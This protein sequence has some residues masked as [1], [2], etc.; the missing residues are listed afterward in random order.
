MAKIEI[1]ENQYN[2]T[3]D[4]YGCSNIAKYI[5]GKEGE[6]QAQKIIL[7]E[8]CLQGIINSVPLDMIFNRPEL[9]EVEE[10]SIDNEEKAEHDKKMT[11]ALYETTD[12]NNL[13]FN[14]LKD[15]ATQKGITVPF[16]TSKD[17]LIKLI[18]SK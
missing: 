13:K 3:C 2:T 16:G 8:E 18:E 15:I 12:L 9:A 5:V 4:I 14:E 10:E 7:C 6:G 11:Y 17:D 1:T